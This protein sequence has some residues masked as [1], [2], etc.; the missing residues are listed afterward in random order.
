MPSHLTEIKRK[1]HVLCAVYRH[2]LPLTLQ[3]DNK[4]LPASLITQTQC[5]PFITLQ[6]C[7]HSAAPKSGKIISFSARDESSLSRSPLAV[8]VEHMELQLMENQLTTSGTVSQW[9]S[10]PLHCKYCKVAPQHRST[11]D[12]IINRSCVFDRN[13]LEAISSATRAVRAYL[14]KESN[15]RVVIDFLW[16]PG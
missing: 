13:A 7:L 11:S 15:A 14:S 5:R 6:S 10:S 16:L 9:E 12:W 3:H 4:T 1:H 8:E 2:W